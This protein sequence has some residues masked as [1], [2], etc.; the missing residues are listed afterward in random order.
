MVKDESA[1]IMRYGSECGAL[2]A[3]IESAWMPDGRVW[4]PHF[5]DIQSRNAGSQSMSV[6][7]R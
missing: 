4:R 1:L 2:R 3:E 7:A 5:I 6:L